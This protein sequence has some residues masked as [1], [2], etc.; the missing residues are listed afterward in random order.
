MISFAFCIWCLLVLVNR[1]L[2]LHQLVLLLHA[3]LIQ[4]NS[5][6]KDA[7]ALLSTRKGEEWAGNLCN[8]YIMSIQ[9][10]NGCACEVKVQIHSERITTTSR[11]CFKIASKC[12]NGIEGTSPVPALTLNGK[13]GSPGQDCSNETC[14]SAPWLN[15]TTSVCEGLQLCQS[16][17][18]CQQWLPQLKPPKP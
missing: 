9:H 1:K 4:L 18:Y 10:H 2:V 11:A 14:E 5:T 16:T 13:A 7:K 17:V 12:S 6:C 15:S 3:W 8:I